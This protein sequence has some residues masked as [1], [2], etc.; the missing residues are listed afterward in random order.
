MP[1]PEDPSR[2]RAIELLSPALGDA[3]ARQS[4]DDAAKA[5]GLEVRWSAGDLRAVIDLV[6]REPG[7][8]GITARVVARRLTK[9]DRPGTTTSDARVANVESG[10]GPASTRGGRSIDTLVELLGPA[11]GDERARSTVT[12]AAKALNLGPRVSMA[13]AMR[14][15]E[16]LAAT[17]GVVGISARFAKTRLHL[18]LW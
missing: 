15:L 11:L 4:V 10:A 13:E 6:A 7:L 17:P 5:L 9:G 3:L 8:V 18:L 12:E 16:H 2:S 1:R 14:L